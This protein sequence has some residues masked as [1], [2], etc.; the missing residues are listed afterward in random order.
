MRIH[1]SR[2]V[3]HTG[4]DGGQDAWRGDAAFAFGRRAAP[5]RHRTSRAMTGLTE[6]VVLGILILAAIILALLGRGAR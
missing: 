6:Y 4:T 1:P 3:P 5:R 2:D